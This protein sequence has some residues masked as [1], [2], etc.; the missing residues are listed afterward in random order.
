[1]QPQTSQT[2]HTRQT[3]TLIAIV[4][5]AAG[6]AGYAAATQ[7]PSIIHAFAASTTN[8]STT[9]T[10]TN[11]TNPTCPNMGEGQSVMIGSPVGQFG[12]PQFQSG[13]VGYQSYQAPTS[14]ASG[15]T[16]TITS[17]SGEF[18]VFGSPTTNGTASATLT[19]T[20]NSLLSRGYV[21]TL[22]SGTVTINGTAYTVSSGTATMNLFA[23][24]ITGQGT[25]SSGGAFEFQ[26]RAS[27][28]FTGT[29]TAR[30]TLDINAGS[31]EYAVLLSGTI[32]G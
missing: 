29:T 25:T 1:M 28:D 18:R 10:S 30:L 17:T 16:I 21:L 5:V 27:G 11:S 23:N 4:A 31:T 14:I 2:P 12:P 13:P 15:T 32:K 7:G 8:T 6:L 26:A 19:F 22:T 20:V 3:A 9:S 24:S